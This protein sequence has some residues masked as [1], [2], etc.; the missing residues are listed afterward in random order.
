MVSKSPPISLESRLP[1]VGSDFLY[2]LN[3]LPGWGG[4][5]DLGCVESH[6]Q[7]VCSAGEGT[8]LCH[9]ESL[10][11]VIQNLV[12]LAAFCGGDDM[13]AWMLD[14]NDGVS[15]ERRPGKNRHVNNVKTSKNDLLTRLRYSQRIDPFQC[16]IGVLD[17]RWANY[18]PLATYGPL[19]S[20]IRPVGHVH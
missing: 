4:G 9:Q 17:Q 7:Y 16:L 20:L 13:M 19:R 8:V 11:L 6:A 5:T 1:L 14:M 10:R 2:I 12:D 3:I 18:G 15:M